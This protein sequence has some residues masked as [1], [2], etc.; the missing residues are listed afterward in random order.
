[1]FTVLWH[2]AAA[3]GFTDHLPVKWFVREGPTPVCTHDVVGPDARVYRAT[4]AVYVHGNT[5]DLNYRPYA[6]VNVQQGMLVGEMRIVFTGSDRRT[7]RE[8]LWRDE[9]SQQFEACNVTLI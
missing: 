9:A 2:E 4:C 7:I 1:M 3:N 6:A 8:V 5:A